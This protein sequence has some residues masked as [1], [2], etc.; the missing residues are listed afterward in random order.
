MSTPDFLEQ[1]LHTHSSTSDGRAP[2]VSMLR[3]AERAG[4]RRIALTDHVRESTAW[5]PDYVREVSLRAAGRDLEVVCGVEAKI[6]DTRGRL[7]LP[8]GLSGVAQVVAADHQF[9]TRQGPM[10][11]QEMSLLLASRR[12][13][14]EDVV[15]DLVDA[16]ARAVYRHERVVVGHLFSVLPKAG[17]DESWVTIEHLE[18]L[19]AA[20]RDAGAAVEVNEK[21]RTPSLRVVDVLRSL[22]VEVVASSDAHDPTAVGAWDHVA[23][24]APV[25]MA[26]G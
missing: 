21:W 25:A 3:A 14:A 2:I 23:A 7:D 11:P 10:T 8:A 12:V 19:A 22:G 16:T 13:R 4:L 18:R 15:A 26:A 17:L 1:D 9:P 5:V 20:C 6:L 24:A